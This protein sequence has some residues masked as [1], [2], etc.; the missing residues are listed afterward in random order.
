[1]G[2]LPARSEPVVS[3]ERVTEEVWTGRAEELQAMQQSQEN[4]LVYKVGQGSGLKEQAFQAEG[5][6]GEACWV[7]SE[8]KGMRE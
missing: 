2:H 6:G 8:D 3:N 7:A 1:M 5:M 4:Q